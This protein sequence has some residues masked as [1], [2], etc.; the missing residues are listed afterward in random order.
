MFAR[1]KGTGLVYQRVTPC[2]DSDLS[3]AAEVCRKGRR[4]SNG[5]TS[6]AA[7]L[8]AARG[9]T[10]SV[11]Y[12]T[13]LGAAIRISVDIPSARDA[14]LEAPESGAG[15]AGGSDSSGDDDKAGV[16]LEI[17]NPRWAK[18][19]LRSVRVAAAFDQQWSL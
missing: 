2:A 12:K 1:V 13:E 15:G 3:R 8:N 16:A 5:G 10:G 18:R 6:A 7:R 14:L 9:V 17:W 4:G 11:M 19:A